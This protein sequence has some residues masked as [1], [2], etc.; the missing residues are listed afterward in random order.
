[1]CSITTMSVC[2]CETVCQLLHLRESLWI[3]SLALDTRAF[4]VS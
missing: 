3:E 1:M 4:V 2:E